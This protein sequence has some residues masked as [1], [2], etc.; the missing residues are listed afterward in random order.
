MSEMDNIRHTPV[1]PEE[2]IGFLNLRKDSVVVDATCG[3]GGHSL[4]IA[5][6]IPG[7]RLICIDRNEPILARAKQ[8]LSGYG[9]ISFHNATFDKIPSILAQEKIPKVDGILADLG[10]SLFHLQD[11]LDGSK[12]LGFSY[13]DTGELSMRLGGD[14]GP[15]A[16][17]VVNKFREFEIADI[18]YKYGEEYESRRIASAI[19]RNRPYT[20]AAELAG[21]IMR[22]KKPRRGGKTHPAAKSFQA[23]RIYVNKELEILESFIPLAV[24]NLRGNGRLVILSYHSLEDRIVKN[25]FKELEKAGFASILT[26]KPLVPSEDE[27]KNNRASRS[28]K[29]RAILKTEVK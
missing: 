24:D 7:G 9:N 14:N 21:V 22:A 8:R 10:I 20:N 25:S 2:T 28:A 29:M 18:L 27:M 12:G 6:H 26:K 1:M 5:Q 3:E 17:D 13:N 15:D 11:R 4:L 19:V 23:L 16:G